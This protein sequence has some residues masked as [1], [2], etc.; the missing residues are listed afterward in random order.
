MFRKMPN[1]LRRF[2]ILVRHILIL[3]KWAIDKRRLPL[4]PDHWEL[5]DIIHRVCIREL[6]RFPNLTDC[7]DFNDKFNG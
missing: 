2:L 6:G 5:Y 7:R 1:I 4:T 3:S